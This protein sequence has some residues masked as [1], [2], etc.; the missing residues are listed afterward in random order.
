MSRLQTMHQ[1]IRNFSDAQKR[2]LARSIT[3]IQANDKKK[4]LKKESKKK[5]YEVTVV[6][7][8]NYLKP[9]LSLDNGPKCKDKYYNRIDLMYKAKARTNKERLFAQAACR[10]EIPHLNDKLKKRKA[11]EELEEATLTPQ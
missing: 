3:V 8:V 5:T 9:T 1:R 10:V 4:D 2:G 11:Q 6:N 7:G